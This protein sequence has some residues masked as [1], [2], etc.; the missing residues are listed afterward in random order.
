MI[1]RDPFQPL[2]FCDSVIP[3]PSETE[4]H[5]SLPEPVWHP[6]GH[7]GLAQHDPRLGAECLSCVVMRGTDF[8]H[9]G[10][11]FEALKWGV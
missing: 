8:L 9:I 5:G 11:F 1:H 7:G 6:S 10:H 2:P 4:P 3:Q